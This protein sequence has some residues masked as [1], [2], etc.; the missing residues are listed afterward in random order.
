MYWIN[1]SR[2]YYP[3]SQPLP[4]ISCRHFPQILP[5]LNFLQSLPNFLQQFINQSESVSS[6]CWSPSPSLQ[7]IL[8]SLASCGG[9]ELTDRSLWYLYLRLLFYPMLLQS[10]WIFFKKWLL[11]HIYCSEMYSDW[12]SFKLYPFSS[13]IDKGSPPDQ[14]TM[15]VHLAHKEIPRHSLEALFYFFENK[16]LSPSVPWHGQIL[17]VWSTSVKKSYPN[18]RNLY[19][20]YLIIL[21]VLSH[22][23]PCIILNHLKLGFRT[24]LSKQNLISQLIILLYISIP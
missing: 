20:H 11:C 4:S 13:T 22:I 17:R 2:V 12:K 14:W 19:I 8:C 5:A 7:L 24:C 23:W 9:M 6:Q 10:Q 3:A 1:G 16:H 15:P 18:T 21:D